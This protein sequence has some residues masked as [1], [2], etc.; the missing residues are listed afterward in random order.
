VA[1]EVAGVVAVAALSRQLREVV[2]ATG[3]GWG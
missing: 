1:G 3:P 2:V